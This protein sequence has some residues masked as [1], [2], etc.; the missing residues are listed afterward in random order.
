MPRSAGRAGFE[1]GFMKLE[2]WQWIGIG[3]SLVLAVV[4]GMA[5]SALLMRL[6]AR[7]AG[8]TR[9]KW[10]DHLIAS[11]RRPTRVFIGL[12]VFEAVAKQLDLPAA[13]AGPLDMTWKILLILT[14]GF[15]AI[16]LI[17][18]LGE[19]LE[20]RSTKGADALQMR[21][22]RTRA[23]VLR[24]VAHVIVFFVVVAVV[25]LQ[26]EVV[27]S[28]GISLLASAGVAGIVLGLAAQKSIGTLLAGIQ[29]SITQPVR[30]G[31]SVVFEGEFGTVEEITLSYVVVKI[32]DGRRLVVP[33]VK[34]LDNTF[35]NWT[36][37]L[38]P[39]LL[40]AALIYADYRVPVQAV[41]EELERFV[42]AHPL[43]DGRAQSLIVNEA[44]ESSVELRALVSAADSGKLF[45]LRCAVREHLVS[46]LQALEG[47]RYLPVRRV[48]PPGGE[49]GEKVV[50]GGGAP[51][52]NGEAHPSSA[53]KGP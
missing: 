26:F 37:V 36:R 6:F 23:A 45:D 17:D 12:L 39:N 31:D 20:E 41:R 51:K 8:Q 46:F 50:L 5:L 14:I 38:E 13:L 15:Y 43:W 35:E 9:A 11:V 30:I 33:I 28:V 48:G 3:A 32:W 19:R 47:G 44:K 52:A 2:L 25:L 42:K 21:G 40:G 7:L 22:A 18:F 10:D 49:E 27:R 24:R 53:A 34:F 4:L 29:L 1:K 16:E